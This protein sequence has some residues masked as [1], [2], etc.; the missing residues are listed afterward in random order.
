MKF[1]N[2]EM[3]RTLCLYIDLSTPKHPL[4]E[5]PGQEKIE[6]KKGQESFRV[7]CSSKFAVFLSPHDPENYYIHV[8]EK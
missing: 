3:K 8:I 4:A 7:I 1:K 6:A 5:N 2:H